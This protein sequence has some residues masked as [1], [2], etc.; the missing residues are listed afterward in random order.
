[1]NKDMLKGRWLQVKGDIRG[2]WGKFTDDDVNQI[3]GDAERMIGKIQEHYGYSRERA[4]QEI[5]EFMNAP[6]GHRRRSA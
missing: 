4:E 3:H 5:N 6:E 2:W 1:M